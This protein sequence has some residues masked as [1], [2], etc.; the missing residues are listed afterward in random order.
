MED[1][2]RGELNSIQIA[3]HAMWKIA[4]ADKTTTSS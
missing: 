4:Q 3:L 2:R 1:F